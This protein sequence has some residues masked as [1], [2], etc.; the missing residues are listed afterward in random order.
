MT[1]SLPLWV[2]P[3][4]PL[5]GF[6]INALLGTRFGKSFVTAVGVGAAG[7]ATLAAYSRLVPFVAGSHATVVE[8]VTNWMTVGTLS[9]DISFRLDPL[10]A[11]MLAFVT[12]VA[13]LIHVYAIG[14]MHHEATD[15]GYARF[16][17]YLN[18]FLFAML[19]LV[20]AESFLLMFVG[21]E[22]V[23]LCSYLLI[24]YYFDLEDAAAAGRKAFVVNRIGDYG[25]LLGMFGIFAAFGSL[26]YTEVFRKAAE[27]PAQFGPALSV[28]CL[29][30]F[31]GAMGKSAQVPLYVWLPDAMA[32]PTPVSALIHAATMVTAGVYMVARCNV[33]FR[34]APEVMLFVAGIGC[35][36]ALFAGTI[37]IAQND[38][39]KVLAYST[40]SQL[41]Y[42]FL[43]CGVGAFAVGMFHVMTHACFKACLFLGAGSVMHAM[44]GDLD[45]RH[46]G[47]LKAK[48]PITYWTFLAA[49]LAIAGIPPFAGFFSK[50]A[51]LSSSFEAPGLG[52]LLWF[53]GLCTAGLTAFYMFRI[54][55]LTFFGE[56]R[57]TK[58]QA[59]HVHESPSSMTFPLVVLGLL[60]V[61]AGWIGLPAVF[62]EHA[63]VIGPFLAPIIAPIAGHEAAHEAL[64]HATEWLLMA[65]S[66]AVAASGLYLA[67]A[68]YAKQGGRTPARL[69]A[70]YPGVYALVAD[71]Y[72]ID[73]L[74]D[75][76]FVRPLA[77]LARTLWKVVDVLIIDGLLNA[78]AFLVELTGDFLRFLQTGNV[79]N[80]ALTF[81]LGLIALLIFVVGAM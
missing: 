66:V 30:L 47:G 8:T 19:T 68:W 50:D 24:G 56:F 10:S 71:K 23:G 29:C 7:L 34:L 45:V 14:Y 27:Q 1:S 58:E 33:L 12:F 60:S 18:L 37:A 26:N 20:L 43:A 3:A 36:T 6:A 69:A 17:A 52:R 74:Y 16:F 32:G 54:V 35:F 51:I 39:K 40:I 80:Y 31:I 77:W 5:A 2:L 28:I 78:A 21:W 38:L 73:E 22:G 63:N 55:S 67:Y 79:R 49:T 72:R 53:V 76:L 75:V 81:F 9:I 57:G 15:A 46:M 59:H 61:V 48:M 44:S 41:G 64:P 62:G 13:F 25:F 4:I 65:V 42:M 11:L 70:S